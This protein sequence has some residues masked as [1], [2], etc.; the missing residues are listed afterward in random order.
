MSVA[1]IAESETVSDPAILS[2]ATDDPL[3]DAAGFG[4]FLLTA[5]IKGHGDELIELAKGESLSLTI[6]ELSF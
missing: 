1:G 2:I 4:L 3:H 6:R 5:M